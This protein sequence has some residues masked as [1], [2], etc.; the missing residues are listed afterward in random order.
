MN[1]ISRVDSSVKSVNSRPIV[2]VCVISYNHSKYISKALDSILNQKTSFPFEILVHDDASTDGTVEIIK[3]YER[4]H[5]GRV[6]GFYESENQYGKYTSYFAQILVRAAKGDYI[7]LCEGDDYWS[8]ENKLE[9]EVGYLE[10]HPDCSQC[11]HSATVLD[12]DS[13]ASI[14]TMGY[15]D[16]E[17]ELNTADLL[18]NWQVPTASRVM[19]TSALATYSRDWPE[20]FPVGD[21]P[22]AIYVS[23]S[24]YAHYFPSQMSAYRYRSKG[25]WTEKMVL[26]SDAMQKNALE[27]IKMLKAINEK[28][29]LKFEPQIRN[30]IK[31]YINYYLI[32]SGGEKSR[33]LLDEG[34]IQTYYEQGGAKRAV[35]FLRALL[36]KLGFVIERDKFGGRGIRV[37]RRA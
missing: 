12:A 17:I 3:Q 22:T 1:T 35:V 2:S 28:T 18:E 7:A 13:G 5:P 4:R 8:C 20:K 30:M 34:V 26:S 16:A 10:S 15:G 27:W 14:G 36:F 23:L 33:A 21:F 29:S 9:I 37:V 19:R 32:F 6:R 25:S 31:D 24:G 11:C